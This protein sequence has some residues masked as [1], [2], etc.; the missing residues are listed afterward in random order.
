MSG[1]ILS[2]FGCSAATQSTM[3]AIILQEDTN[4]APQNPLSPTWHPCEYPPIA[5]WD[6]GQTE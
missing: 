4:S 3:I 6:Q 5:G 1:N 2:W